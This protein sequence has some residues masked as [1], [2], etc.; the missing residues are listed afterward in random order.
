MIAV[1]ILISNK[2]TVEYRNVSINNQ[3]DNHFVF[4]ID[5]ISIISCE[6]VKFV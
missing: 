5:F 3:V 1:R 2:N 6:Y 4:I